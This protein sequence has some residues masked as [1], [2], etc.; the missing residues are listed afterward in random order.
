MGTHRLS[1]V[2]V[3]PRTGSPARCDPSFQLW[4]ERFPNGPRTL[5]SSSPQAENSLKWPR[6]QPDAPSAGGAAELPPS[7]P[8]LESP[9]GPGGAGG[10]GSPVPPDACRGGRIHPAATFPC[11]SNDSVYQEPLWNGDE[12]PQDPLPRA[13]G[14]VLLSKQDPRPWWCGPRPGSSSGRRGATGR[15]GACFPPRAEVARLR[16]HPDHQEK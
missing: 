10:P 1:H 9:C 13:H 3:S 12:P 2:S 14:P 7:A 11:P 4:G 16:V 8:S 15:V 5:L 6:L